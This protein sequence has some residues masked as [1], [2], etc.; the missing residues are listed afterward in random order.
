MKT[1]Q[2]DSLWQFV[3]RFVKHAL[4]GWVTKRSSSLFLRGRD[5]I[6]YGP[7]IHGVHEEAL[8]CL[9]ENLAAEGSSD[10]LIDIGANIGLT[11]AQNGASFRRVVCYEPNPLCVHVLKVNLAIAL[12]EEKF[13]IHEYGLGENDE[14]LQLYVPKHNWGGAFIKS[15]H[16]DYSDDV[17]AKKDGFASF[18]SDNYVISNVE[19]RK[20]NAALESLF[21]ELN[22][23]SL[24]NGV[25]KIDVEGYEMIV[26]EALASALPPQFRPV[27]IFENFRDDLDFSKTV[28]LF[29]NHQVSV[30]KIERT[31][32]SKSSKL[33]KLLALLLGKKDHHKLVSIDEARSSG[34]DIVLDLRS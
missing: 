20:A 30:C 6:S 29:A 33:S 9:I 13:V 3:N 16:N 18:D 19:V 25:I 7:L 23:E 26:L 5:V 2:I 4:F 28:D 27:I 32:S 12:N 11:S 22:A 17:L 34:G 15:S 1:L 8:T 10:F 24:I 21:T 31:L 14:V